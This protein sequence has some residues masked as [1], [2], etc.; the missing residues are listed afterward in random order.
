V[1]CESFGGGCPA[2]D[3]RVLGQRPGWLARPQGEGQSGPQELV[4][5]TTVKSVDWRLAIPSNGLEMVVPLA[6]AIVTAAALSA[7]G[8]AANTLSGSTGR[9]TPSGAAPSI[10]ASSSTDTTP[11]ATATS[12]HPGK[13][14]VHCL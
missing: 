1:P 9:S 3:L 11:P 5:G 12:P 2:R 10:S 7:C 8:G 14:P 4:G 13:S 6:V